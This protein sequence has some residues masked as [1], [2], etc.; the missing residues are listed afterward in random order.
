M[1]ADMSA[2]EGAGTD[3]QPSGERHRHKDYKGQAASTDSIGQP[4]TVNPGHRRQQRP[5]K[6][7]LDGM[8]RRARRA[9]S[10]RQEVGLQ[11]LA[12]HEG[13]ADE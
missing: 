5:D 8:Q 12:K 6:R 9:L 1:L 3:Q 10:A 13:E 2:F 4:A 7:Q 11:H